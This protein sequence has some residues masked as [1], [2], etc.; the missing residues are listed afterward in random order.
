MM[1]VMMIFWLVSDQT[2]CFPLTLLCSVTFGR[3]LR[4]A[5]L[6]FSSSDVVMILK[7]GMGFGA[8]DFPGVQL[9]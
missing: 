1:T 6:F 7:T 3:L 8:R 4:L 2:S 5:K 9:S